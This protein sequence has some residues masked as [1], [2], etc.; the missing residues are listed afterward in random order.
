MDL[1]NGIKHNHYHH[2]KQQ[3]QQQQQQQQELASQFNSIPNTYVHT[4]VYVRMYTHSY[5]VENVNGICTYLFSAFGSTY[6]HIYIVVVFFCCQNL[7]TMSLSFLHLVL[8]GTYLAHKVASVSYTSSQ[9]N[10][11]FCHNN[12]SAQESCH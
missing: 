6:Q 1:C 2:H 11:S 5:F 8:S 9:R 4:Y 7:Y 10:G 3:Q 12:L